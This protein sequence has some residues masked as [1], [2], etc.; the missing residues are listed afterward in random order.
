MFE[1][2]VYY[3][4]VLRYTI[5]ANWDKA[6][7]SWDKGFYVQVRE[8]PG[9]GLGLGLDGWR[10]PRSLP[11]NGGDDVIRYHDNEMGVHK[12][13]GVQSYAEHDTFGFY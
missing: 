1:I 11:V 4:D 7:E 12:P 9:Q 6:R 10:S 13:A 2:S 3:D 5:I 8:A